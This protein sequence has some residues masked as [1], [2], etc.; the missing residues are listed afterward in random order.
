MIITISGIPGSG[1][2]T[3]AK[4]LAKKLNY[5]HYSMGDLRGRIAIKHGLTIDKL[6]EIGK[7]EIWTDKEAD[8][9][10]VRLGKKDNLVIDTWV[11]FHFL[12]NSIKIF[13]ETDPRI[14]AE[15]VFKDQRPD[16]AKK[17]TIEE[18][19][20]MLKKRLEDSNARFK[21]YYN[22]NILDKSHYDLIIDTTNIT[23]EQVI[24]KILEYIEYKR[25]I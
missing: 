9:E 8:D 7:T 22:L 15:R 16:E 23:P 25:K 20:E 13:L 2:S 4:L 24:N 1:K 3:I 6:N 12:P 21:K 19:E 17:K 11:G 5:K 14:G 18:V 10:L